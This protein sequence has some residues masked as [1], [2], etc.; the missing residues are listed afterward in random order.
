MKASVD[1]RSEHKILHRAG[2]GRDGQQEGIEVERSLDLRCMPL[3]KHKLLWNSLLDLN[4][5]RNGDRAN[6]RCSDY[7]FWEVAQLMIGWRIYECGSGM[8]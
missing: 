4:P 5:A 6:R 1:L 3:S 2:T 8:Q 7:S